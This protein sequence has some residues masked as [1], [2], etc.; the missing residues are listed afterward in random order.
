MGVHDWTIYQA[1]NLG[2]LVYHDSALAVLLLSQ[3]VSNSLSIG[4]ES[5]QCQTY[6]YE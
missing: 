2:A 3:F 6:Y 1:L 5:H 4:S